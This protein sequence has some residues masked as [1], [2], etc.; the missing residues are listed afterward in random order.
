MMGGVYPVGSIDS[1]KK[2]S[3]GFSERPFHKNH[4]QLYDFI[5]VLDWPFPWGA[6][7]YLFQTYGAE[8]LEED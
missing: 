3:V 2:I 8:E 5:T 1:K 6:L 7:N 4:G